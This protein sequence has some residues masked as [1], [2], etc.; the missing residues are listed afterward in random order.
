MFLLPYFRDNMNFLNFG[1][2]HPRDFWKSWTFSLFYSSNFKI[3]PKSSSQTCDYKYKLNR[4]IKLYLVVS[5]HKKWSFPLRISLVNVTKSWIWSHLLKKSLMENSIF[6]AV[7]VLFLK[8]LI[9]KRS[10]VTVWQ[11]HHLFK[12]ILF[13]GSFRYVFTLHKKVVSVATVKYF[14]LKAQITQILLFSRMQVWERSKVT[15]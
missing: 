13:S 11:L 10:K 5:L 9:W 6:C 8:M 15:A 2:N 14:F 1:I 4:I 12:K 7:I 3:H